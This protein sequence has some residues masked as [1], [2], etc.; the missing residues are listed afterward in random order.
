MTPPLNPMVL[1][2]ENK[3]RFITKIVYN[4]SQILLIS[5]IFASTVVLINGYLINKFIPN[6][7]TTETVNFDYSLTKPKDVLNLAPDYKLYSI[8]TPNT[9]YQ[10]QI[11]LSLPFH[12][13][14]NILPVMMKTKFVTNQGKLISSSQKLIP[15]KQF[16]NEKI[17]LI[18]LVN[19]TVTWFFNLDF[20]GITNR[21]FD[22][23]MRRLALIQ[24]SNDYRDSAATQQILLE[25]PDLEINHS[26][27]IPDLLELE[28]SDKLIMYSAQVIIQADTFFSRK[29]GKIFTLYT[30]LWPVLMVFLIIIMGLS[31]AGT[32]MFYRQYLFEQFIDS[33]AL[34]KK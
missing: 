34:E 3:I 16:P 23:C 13:N 9:K 26:Q 1:N 29:F 22:F 7:G 27:Q 30:T 8:F 12:Q 2:N 18:Q 11:F 33:S 20:T 4:C 19:Y 28:I 15:Y 32:F 25:M 14:L 6:Q 21:I 24:K 31:F 10:I 17:S 5:S